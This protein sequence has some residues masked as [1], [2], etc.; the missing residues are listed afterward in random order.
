M[1][2][3]SCRIVAELGE[4]YDFIIE[5]DVPVITLC[6]DSKEISKYGAHNQRSI[7]TVKV[8]GKT[9]YGNK[10]RRG[11]QMGMHVRIVGETSLSATARTKGRKTK[12]MASCT[13]MTMKNGWK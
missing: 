12:S 8:R 3:Y 10:S 4:S 2:D 11:N 7:V 6:P 13:S 1:L 5:A 9:A